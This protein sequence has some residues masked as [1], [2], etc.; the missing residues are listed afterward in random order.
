MYI[1]IFLHNTRETVIRVEIS[2]TW[3]KYCFEK[4][5]TRMA[6]FRGRQSRRTFA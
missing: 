6:S 3:V 2:K 5:C 1:Y 4:Y